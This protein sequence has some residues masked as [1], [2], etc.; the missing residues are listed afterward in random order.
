[1]LAIAGVLA[2]AAGFLFFFS[3]QT[4]D[5]IAGRI[6]LT[7][8]PVGPVPPADKAQAVKTESAKESRHAGISQ[9]FKRK[10]IVAERQSVAVMEAAARQAA[11][12]KA[13]A[14][15]V[16]VPAQTVEQAV[17]KATSI[18]QKH[19]IEKYMYLGGDVRLLVDGRPV[20]AR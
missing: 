4:I 16:P 20:L 10:E 14:S 6:G 9:F 12:D 15:P 8:Q 3:P 11:E 13:K 2:I 7:S 19:L 5:N 17:I 1:M 18:E